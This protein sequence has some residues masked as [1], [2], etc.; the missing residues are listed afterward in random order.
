MDKNWEALLNSDLL[1]V[2]DDFT[3]RVMKEIDRVPQRRTVQSTWY[4]RLQ[5]LAS[6]FGGRR[7]LAKIAVFVFGILAV[8]AAG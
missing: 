7:G 2:P 1:D 4:E 8:S 5:N 3:Q 6:I